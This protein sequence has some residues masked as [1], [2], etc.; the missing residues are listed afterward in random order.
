MPRCETCGHVVRPPGCG[1]GGGGITFFF[2]TGPH[3]YYPWEGSNRMKL[4]PGGGHEGMGEEQKW[5]PNTIQE[6]KPM[7]GLFVLFGFGLFI[8]V[9]GIPLFFS[10]LFI[11]FKFNIQVMYLSAWVVGGV[12][13]IPFL[14]RTFDRCDSWYYNETLFAKQL[15]R[16]LLNLNRI[17]AL[18]MLARAMAVGAFISQVGLIVAFQW[19]LGCTWPIAY[20]FPAGQWPSILMLI[21]IIVYFCLLTAQIVAIENAWE[22]EGLY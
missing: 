10:D 18:T 19:N 5:I 4:C 6:S 17:R 13:T 15:E 7:I 2:Q 14:I 16:Y 8:F 22:K 3:Y 20:A 21:A 1:R 9:C 12:L 11:D